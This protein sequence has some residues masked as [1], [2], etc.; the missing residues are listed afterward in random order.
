MNIPFAPSS[1]GF[2]SQSLC[3]EPSRVS[4]RAPDIRH[5]DLDLVVKT[6]TCV[7]AKKPPYV[8]L[9]SAHTHTLSHPLTPSHTPLLLFQVRM[10]GVW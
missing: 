10:K 5:Q 2:S 8:L 4:T 9:R 6:W 7:V 3:V 1:T